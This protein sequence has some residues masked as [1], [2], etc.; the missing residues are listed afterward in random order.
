M[1]VMTDRMRMY[2]KG[3]A[4]FYFAVMSD[5]QQPIEGMQTFGS[6]G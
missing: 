2:I 4:G 5:S 3:K 1:M 6:H